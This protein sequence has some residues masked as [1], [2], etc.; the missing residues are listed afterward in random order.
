MYDQSY[1]C[2]RPQEMKA[3]A[4]D[5]PSALPAW[6]EGVLS[7]SRWRAG[8]FFPHQSLCRN[9]TKLSFRASS[10]VLGETRNPGGSCNIKS[11]WIPAPIPLRGTWPG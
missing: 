2:D 11:F 8:L 5:G 6:V 3:P 1:D 4:L 10:T 9:S 7:G